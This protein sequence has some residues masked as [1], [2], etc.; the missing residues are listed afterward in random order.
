MIG[1]IQ[2]VAARSD[3]LFFNYLLHAASSAAM[4]F[5]AV[6]KEKWYLFHG[7]EREEY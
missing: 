7:C 4:S 1:V 6:R 3:C 5:F 2:H